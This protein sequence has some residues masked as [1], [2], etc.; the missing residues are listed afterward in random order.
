[1]LICLV[2]H[3]ANNNA[4][5]SSN[6]Q[7]DRGKKTKKYMNEHTTCNCFLIRGLFSLSET[8]WAKLETLVCPDV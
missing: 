2:T 8:S 3:K 4:F 7:D 1:M 6:N 5:Y